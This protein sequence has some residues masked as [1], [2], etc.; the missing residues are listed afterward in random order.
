MDESQRLWLRK[1][2]IKSEVKTSLTQCL[3]LLTLVELKEI[4]ENYGLTVIPSVKK[5]KMVL[6]LFKAITENFLNSYIYFTD[7]QE[8]GFN[9]II[10]NNVIEDADVFNAT[11][12]I[13]YKIGIAF[14]FYNSNK[15]YL[16]IPS[17]IVDIYNHADITE[18]NVTKDKN[19]E[20]HKYM[21]ALCNLY[22]IYDSKQFIKVYNAYHEEKMSESDFV[23]YAKIMN[24]RQSYFSVE[25]EQNN[26]CLVFAGE[27]EDGKLFQMLCNNIDR[28]FYMPSK[29]QID[30]FAVEP[31]EDTKQFKK[32]VNY[33]MSNKLLEGTKLEDFIDDIRNDCQD[34]KHPLEIMET[35]NR[36]G[37][38]FKRVDDLNQLM[39]LIIDMSNHERKWVLKGYSP[40]MLNANSNHSEIV[41][42][43]KIGR[44]DPCPCGSRK[45][46]KKCCGQ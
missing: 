17:E 38:S 40:V 28:P 30:F 32:F 4:G 35:V 8:E 12:Y 23:N 43:S 42:P 45:K 3:A 31:Y 19:Q 13:L 21:M 20:I 5:P 6:I 16:T 1:F 29:A 2:A 46:Y 11:Y 33:V 36:Y 14:Y 34:D 22:G 9:K 18:I 10:T 41:K 39:G 37:I 15:L 27:D 24:L 44:N 7:S 26:N 25:H